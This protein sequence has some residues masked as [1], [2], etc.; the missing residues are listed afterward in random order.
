MWSRINRDKSEII[1][2][3]PFC[4]A[5]PEPKNEFVWLGY[6]LK[7]T[8]DFQLLFTVSRSQNKINLSRILL[9]EIFQYTRNILARFKIYKIFIAPVIEVF[10]PAYIMSPMDGRNT[11]NKFHHFC[12][13]SVLCLPRSAPIIRCCI[14]LGEPTLKTRTFQT[15]T[16]LLPYFGNF[17]DRFAPGMT[18]RSGRQ[19]LQFDD[20]AL[21]NKDFCDRVVWMA[22]TARVCPDILPQAKKFSLSFALSESQRIR[23]NIANKIR[24]R[25]SNQIANL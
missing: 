22:N 21:K 18:L 6:S 7:L 20:R 11:L 14:A 25:T 3:D 15:A 19:M 13:S 10:I 4:N 24:T 8:I 5:D 2:P 23:R 1:L 16:R 17:T 9:T 12:L